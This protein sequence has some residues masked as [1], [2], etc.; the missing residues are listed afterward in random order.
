MIHGKDR[1]EISCVAPGVTIK[2]TP[3]ITKEVEALTESYRTFVQDQQRGILAEYVLL[4]K[5][6]I[7]ILD[8]YIGFREDTETHHLEEA[9][10]KLVVPMRSSSAEMEITDHNLWLLDDR[11]AF[12]SHFASDMRFKAYTDDSSLDRPDIAFFYDNCFAWQERDAGN[13][14]VLVEFKRPGRETYNGDDNPLRQVINYIERFQIANLRDVKGKIVSARL[15]DAAFHCYI[16]ADLT[17]KLMA[18]FKGHSFHPTP[19]GEGLVGFIRNP[20][21]FIEV[22]SYQ[23]ML[24]DARMRNAIFFQKLGITDVDPSPTGTSSVSSAPAGEVED[25]EMQEAVAQEL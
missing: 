19:D 23:K 12:Y 3:E 14:V 1:N 4:R 24:S 15:K 8:K 2:A 16:V 18:A 5:S 17:P 11:L 6:V 9:V 21:A 7:D 22:V 10:H 25:D 13:T 20:D